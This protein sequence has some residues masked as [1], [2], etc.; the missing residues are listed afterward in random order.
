MAVVEKASV[1]K[2]I[3]IKIQ[4]TPSLGM[5]RKHDYLTFKTK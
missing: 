2:E 5:A 4:G 1:G 3:Q